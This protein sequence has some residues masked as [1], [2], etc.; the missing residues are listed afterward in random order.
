MPGHGFYHPVLVTDTM[1]I[2]HGKGLLTA[3][4]SPEKALSL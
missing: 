4:Q 3:T 1:R 2:I